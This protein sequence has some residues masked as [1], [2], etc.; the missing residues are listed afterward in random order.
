MGLPLTALAKFHLLSLSSSHTVVSPLL[1]SLL[2]PFV[3][4][5][6]CSLGLV[7]RAHSDVIYASR[8]F[9]FQLGRITFDNRNQEQSLGN[10]WGRALRL[11]CQRVT[12]SR[13]SPAATQSDEDSLHALS[14]FF[15]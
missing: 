1:T 4:K 8:L 13:R 3:V 10:R 15:L 14:M 6:A 5:L 11:V 2:C 7:R 12:R 9:L